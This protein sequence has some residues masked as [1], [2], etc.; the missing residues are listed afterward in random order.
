VTPQNLPRVEWPDRQVQAKT[1]ESSESEETKDLHIADLH[2]S[3]YIPIAKQGEPL[4]R[5]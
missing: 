4:L 1:V 3:D 2:V 5:A